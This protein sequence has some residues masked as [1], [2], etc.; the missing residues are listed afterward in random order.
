VN[1][2][3]R[4]ALVWLATV[5]ESGFPPP[6]PKPVIA[7]Y[8]PGRQNKI[9]RRVSDHLAGGFQGYLQTHSHIL[10]QRAIDPE[11]ILQPH[12]GFLAG[13]TDGEFLP[14]VFKGPCNGSTSVG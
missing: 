9:L 12:H 5:L 13:R 8:I 14:C 3:Y 1:T 11:D 4:M 6:A 2:A 10:E 7:M